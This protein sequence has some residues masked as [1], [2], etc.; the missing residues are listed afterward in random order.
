MMFPKDGTT[1]EK[2][3][4]LTREIETYSDF[5]Q[6]SPFRC[7]VAYGNEKMNPS[8]NET[9]V[10]HSR[11][12]SEAFSNLTG[13]SLEDALNIYWSRFQLLDIGYRVNYEFKT[14]KVSSSFA[15]KLLRKLAKKY[16]KQGK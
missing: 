11:A 9:V 16:K 6:G 2:L 1:P 3:E 14:S 10:L 4:W 13:I 7:V 5:D 15:A 8:V 12:H